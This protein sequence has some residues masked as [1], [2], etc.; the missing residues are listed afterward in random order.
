MGTPPSPYEF[1]GYWADI[2]RPEDYDRANEEFAS[3]QQILLPG[4]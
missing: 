4:S 3:I 1:S 2:G